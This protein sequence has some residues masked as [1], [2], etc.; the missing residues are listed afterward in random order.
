MKVISTN[1]RFKNP[2]GCRLQRYSYSVPLTTHLLFQNRKVLSRTVLT[3]PEK[4]EIALNIATIIWH[5]NLLMIV[6]SILGKNLLYLS[7]SC[8]QYGTFILWIP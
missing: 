8:I 2:D 6:F 1:T 5:F 4:N 7:N 3:K